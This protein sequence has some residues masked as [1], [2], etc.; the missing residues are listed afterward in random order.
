MTGNNQDKETIPLL[1]HLI[2]LAL[3]E[4][5]AQRKNENVQCARHPDK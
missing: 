5:L 3:L 1:N 2:L 4:K